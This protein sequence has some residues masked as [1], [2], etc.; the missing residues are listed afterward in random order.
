MAT[1]LYNS[2]LETIL[3]NCKE[4]FI[5]DTYIA[6]VHLSSEVNGKYLIQTCSDSKADLVTLVLKY[7]KAS[8]KTIFNCLVK[9][10]KL[11]ILSFDY[12]LGSF[13]LINMENMTLSKKEALDKNIKSSDITGYTSIRS[14]FF[15]DEFSSMKAREKRIVIY[16]AQLSDSKA[17]NFHN[18]F[19]MNLLKP[20]SPWLKILKTKS[21]YYAKYTIEKMLYKY[22]DV[23]INN[24]EKL[25]ENDLAPKKMKTFKFSF[26]CNSIWKRD[27][28]EKEFEL[29]K[30][31]NIKE[32]NFI[33]EKLRFS[34][35]TLSKKKIMHLIR[36]ISN[37]RKWHIKERI[38]QIVIN[39][40]RAI[41]V[42]KSRED[43]KSLPAYLTSITKCVI[44]EFKEFESVRNAVSTVNNLNDNNI[45]LNDMY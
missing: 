21:K 4:Y 20:N 44:L 32:Y 17:S 45:Y 26:C 34:E 40:Y 5:I 23:F 43:I 14:F 36:G 24:S 6:L 27:T 22:N 19:T 12:E 13:I 8:Y 15:G 31:T 7:V 35:V 42:Y 3:S 11:N 9:L 39:K 25:R 1:K 18:G 41:Q 33:M 16:L 28:E 29:V 38:L 10:I 2:H 37:I 30:L